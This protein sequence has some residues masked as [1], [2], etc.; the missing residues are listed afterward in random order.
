[1]TREEYV[2]KIREVVD[3]YI[4]YLKD[5]EAFAPY[6]AY[7]TAWDAGMDVMQEVEQERDDLED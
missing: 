3:E 5:E 2:K 1:M 4:K 6:E 7:D